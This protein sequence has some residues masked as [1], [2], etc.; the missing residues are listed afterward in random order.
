M[1]AF[2]ARVYNLVESHKFFFLLTQ[3][4]DFFIELSPRFG[5]CCNDKFEVTRPFLLLNIGRPCRIGISATV[6]VGG[7]WKA[8]V[9]VPLWKFGTFLATLRTAD[10]LA[11]RWSSRDLISG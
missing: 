7:A 9:H 4:F 5:R 11:R 10:I 6:N 1:L 2:L 8:A 3:L